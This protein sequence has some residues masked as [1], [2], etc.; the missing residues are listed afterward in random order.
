MDHI[1]IILVNYDCAQLTK[2]CLKSLQ[3][4][5]AKNFNY[6]VIIVDN[7]SQK[8][9]KLSKSLQASNIEV[10]RSE[11]N[12]GFS[13]GNN[14]G[15]TY[16][17][18]HYNP[19]YICLL[20][21]D[22]T[23]EPNFLE[24][25]HDCIKD[26]N[27]GGMVSPKI[28]FAKGFEYHQEAY[29]KNELGNIIWYGGGSI[30]WPNL[31]AFHRGVDEIDRGQLDI[32]GSTDF[33]TGCCILISREVLETVGMLDDNLFLYYEDVDLSLRAKREGF[34][35]LYCPD[36]VIWHH[37]AGSSG[38]VGSPLHTYYQTRNRVFMGLKYGSPRIKITS[39]SYALRTLFNG[40]PI[41]RK[42][43]AHALIGK[44]GKQPY[45]KI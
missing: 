42:A 27:P 18:E 38:G 9:L 17:A 32:E 23:V 7:A 30:D 11:S 20:N 6:S 41:E 2:I 44:M 43:A 3:D 19:D 21:N 4:I 16:A 28:Y 37:N 8:P 24:Y 10:I 45:D 39:I 36:A 15:I 31:I 26:K 5:K 25:L 33:C 29:P 22:T 1:S 40:D 13:G 34:Q 12:L 35:V 14:L